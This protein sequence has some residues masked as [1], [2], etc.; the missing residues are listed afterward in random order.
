MKTFI[1]SLL[2][3]GGISTAALAQSIADANSKYEA[4]DYKA[5][6]QMYDQA[7]KD[8]KGGSSDH[9]NAACSWALAGDKSKAFAHLEK[10]VEKGW[11]DIS[12]MKQDSDLSSLRDD[13]RWAQLVQQLQTKVDKA[14]A[15]YNKPLK[16]QLE[17]IHE[18]DQKYRM[19]L[20]QVQQEHGPQSEQFQE[21]IRK[22]QATDKENLQQVQAIIE[23]HGWP[24]KSL[25]GNKASNAA[26]LVIQHISPEEKEIMEGYLPLLREAAAK[27]ELSKSSVALTEDRVR[28]Y[29][30]QPQVYGSQVRTNPE[31][32]KPEFY[33]IEDE[34]N[35][36]KRRAAVGLEP[37]REYAKRFGFE[38]TPAVPAE[39]KK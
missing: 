9:Y 35:V 22:M 13:K 15:N 14:E 36:D 17:R 24:G 6:G 20:G 18:T 4:K 1:L 16:E 8:G 21:L 29:N 11:M 30:N 32:N 33:Q 12:H 38:Y 25:V 3:A 5:S 7:L 34:A 37:L 28:M 19:M 10:A 31:T 2:L 39:T 27:G 26:W 23:K